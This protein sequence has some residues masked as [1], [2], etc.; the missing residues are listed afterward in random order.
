MRQR[1]R[2]KTPHGDVFLMST[3]Y[4]RETTERQLLSTDIFA[5][6][7]KDVLF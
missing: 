6:P 7:G 1:A 5:F 3:Q 4:L 2:L